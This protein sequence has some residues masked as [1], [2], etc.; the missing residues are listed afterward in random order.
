MSNRNW[1]LGLA[2]AAVAISLATSS[3]AAITHGELLITQLDAGN[4]SVS[5][6]TPSVSV[7][8][9]NRSS[10]PATLIGGNRADYDL[11]FGDG[12]TS[13]W[14][15]GVVITTVSQNTRNNDTAGSTSGT[16]NSTSAISG[17]P[18]NNYFTIATF[19]TGTTSGVGGEEFNV[20]VAYAYFPYSK[21]LGGVAINSAGTNGG[22]NDVLYATP[23]ITLGTH[24]IDNGG[25]QT[26][27]DLRQFGADA[28]N[29]ILLVNHAKNED[30]FALSQPNADGTFTVFVKDNGSDA[31]SYEQDPMAFVFVSV[32]DDNVAALG[33]ITYGLTAEVT[34]GDYSITNIAVGRYLLTIAGQDNDSG[35]LIVSAEGGQSWNRDNIVNYEWDATLGGWVIESRDLP[36]AGLQGNASDTG[37]APQ[38]A[39]SFAFITSNSVPEPTAL[40]LLPLA[41]PLLA[42]RSRRK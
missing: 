22:A 25:G 7:N 27:I 14:N 38:R 39:F 11:Y 3:Y 15:T 10:G 5:S 4:N 42:R 19:A 16:Q 24:V 40:S 18:T 28:S 9:I 21:Y 41:T 8:L 13:D 26:T 36:N 31:A 6:V 12:T 2:S 20:N 34:K 30:N 33:R 29:G 35:T 1:T 17:R 23:G 32:D 37:Q